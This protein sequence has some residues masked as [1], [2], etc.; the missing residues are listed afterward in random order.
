MEHHT[1]NGDK[2]LYRIDERTL[3]MSE[4]V[5]GLKQEF[6]EMREQIQNRYVSRD[7]FQP[8]KNIVYGMVGVIMVAVC[9][10]VLALIGL[11][12]L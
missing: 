6:H 7:E 11:K 8:V 12:A 10:A 2:L 5:A 4:V 1:E 9:G 3:L